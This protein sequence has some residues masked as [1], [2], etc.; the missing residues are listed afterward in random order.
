[1]E[2]VVC[3]KCHIAVK[4][5]DF[6]CFNCGA[7]L[8]PKPLNTTLPYQLLLY[9]GSIFL[10]PLGIIWGIRYLR[11]VNTTSKIIGIILIILTLIS[12]IVAIVLSI[13]IINSV[14]S[15]V[16]KQLQMLNNY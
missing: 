6:F 12:L 15:Q 5:T 4:G 1:M 2:N 9:L 3:P 8:K 14:N 10:P 7:N 16:T 11:E 13:N